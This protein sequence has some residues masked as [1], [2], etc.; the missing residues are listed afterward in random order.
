MPGPVRLLLSGFAAAAGSAAGCAAAAAAA[1]APAA[2]TAAAALLDARLA[3]CWSR[4]SLA[5]PPEDK[6]TLLL[7][8]CRWRKQCPETCMR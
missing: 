3:A 7:T 5:L 6:L 1:V 8:V 2:L 4:P